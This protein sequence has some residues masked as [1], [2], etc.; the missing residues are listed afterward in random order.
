ME[1]FKQSSIVNIL[2]RLVELLKN[3]LSS[4]ESSS[5]T[6]LPPLTPTAAESLHK[7]LN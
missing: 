3:A 5:N 7:A 2:I 6:P 1:A 4:S